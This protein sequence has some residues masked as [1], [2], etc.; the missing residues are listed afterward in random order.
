MNPTAVAH[1]R[2]SA[3]RQSN[4]AYEF[5]RGRDEAGQECWQASLRVEITPSMREA[6]LKEVVQ[7]ADYVSFLDAF[8]RQTAIL[9][10]FR[11]SYLAPRRRARAI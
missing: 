2:L 5:V 8:G 6:G 10:R 1:R 4:P 3:L 11:G 7:R 9:Y